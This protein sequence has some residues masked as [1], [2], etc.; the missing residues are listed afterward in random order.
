MKEEISRKSGH[1]HLSRRQGR[2]D[3]QFPLTPTRDAQIF[4][5]QPLR[6]DDRLFVGQILLVI[7]N[8]YYHSII[9]KNSNVF[10]KF[11]VIFVI[12]VKATNLLFKDFEQQNWFLFASKFLIF[13]LQILNKTKSLLKKL[14]KKYLK[15]KD[16][17]L[18]IFDYFNNSIERLLM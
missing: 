5:A 10:A 14:Y 6:A 3:A 17:L 8:I 13:T 11:V 12:D 18:I 7:S 4:A 16:Y 1:S 15:K 2:E 9:I